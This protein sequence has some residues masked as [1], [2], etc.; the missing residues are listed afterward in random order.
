MKLK[1]EIELLSVFL[2]DFL[3]FEKKKAQPIWLSFNKVKILE[4][5]YF[6]EA[7]RPSIIA[8]IRLNCCVRN[9]NRCGPNA[10]VSRKLV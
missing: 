7:Y 1:G 5:C 10:I 9:G 2:I 4:M 6:P 3:F 8:A